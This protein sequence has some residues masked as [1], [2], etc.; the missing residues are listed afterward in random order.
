M[1]DDSPL[2]GL[3]TLLQEREEHV[4][5]IKEID[6]VVAEAVSLLQAATGINPAVKAGRMIVAAPKVDRRRAGSMVE[7]ILNHIAAHPGLTRAEVKGAVRK[8]PKFANVSENGFYNAVVRAI[9]KK[10]LAEV[11]G[12]LYSPGSA[13][14]GDASPDTTVL[15][16]SFLKGSTLNG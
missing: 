10:E 11:N 6:E 3:K 12:R 1:M 16:F 7:F 14:K 5:R 8:H 15:P 13:P 4:A 2:A 9:E